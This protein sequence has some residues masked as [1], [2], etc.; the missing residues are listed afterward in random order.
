MAELRLSTWGIK[1]PI[2]VALLFI[3]A[4][5]GGTISY[6]F[7]PIK[8]FPNVVFP[9][10]LVVVTDNGAAPAEMK[11]QITRPIEDAMAGI[12]GVRAVQSEVSQG[13]STT[14]IQFELGE[15]LQKVTDEVRQR[16]DQARATLPREIDPPQVE[17]L[18]ID[19][20]PIL[21]YAVASPTMSAAD[22]SWFVD[23]TISRSLQSE[24]GVAQVSRVGGVDREINVI[25]DPDRMAAQGLTATS[26]NAALSA[27]NTDIPGG[28]VLVG[29]R[30][31]TVRVLGSALTVI[32]LRN[33]TI[34]TVGGRYVKLSDVADVGDGAGEPRGFARLDNRPVVGFQVLKTNDA[35]EVQVE[36]AVHANIAR[37]QKTYPDVRFT[38]IFSTV[39]DTRASYAAT[40]RTMF[41]GMALAS[42]VV[43]LF[44][45]DWRSTAIVAVAM[46]V[47]LVPTFLVMAIFHFS[48]NLITLLAL[49]LVIGILVDDAIVEIENIQKRVQAGARPYRA[50]MEGADQIGLAVVAT[51]ASI[52]VVFAPVSFM[53]SIPG[54]FFKEFGITVVVS[55]LFSLL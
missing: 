17:R 20:S 53:G 27:F 4:V 21:T 5:I 54:Q 15:D 44:L 28:R 36:D 48:L 45:R 50:S 23:D 38:Q 34:P 39:D 11:T 41:E 37:M 6:N 31:Q 14:Q 33:L 24:K 46:P 22:L 7:L 26:L 30:E 35:S 40:L 12:A 2:P 32:Q 8:H 25:V 29:G 43:F 51:T 55:V 9:A 1:N 19:S 3:A 10:V 47:S 13:V 52:V 16:V 49:T 18:E 42:L